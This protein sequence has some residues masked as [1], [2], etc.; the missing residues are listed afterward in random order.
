MIVVIGI[1]NFDMMNSHKYFLAQFS[2]CK[3]AQLN[4]VAR[5]VKTARGT[6]PAISCEQVFY[7]LG[8]PAIVFPD[9]RHKKTAVFPGCG[10]A[11]LVEFSR[12]INEVTSSV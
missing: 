9:F 8:L 10:F 2:R 1:T 12:S 7:S 5:R 11:R 4:W 3:M 6:A